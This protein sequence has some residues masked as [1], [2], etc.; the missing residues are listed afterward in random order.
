[1]DKTFVLPA[2]YESQVQREPLTLENFHKPPYMV[3]LIGSDFGYTEGY[4][5]KIVSKTWGTWYPVEVEF[6]GEIVTY[7]NIN[8]MCYPIVFYAGPAVE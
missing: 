6:D 5:D 8:G 7:R 4:P 3:D 2:K 1:M